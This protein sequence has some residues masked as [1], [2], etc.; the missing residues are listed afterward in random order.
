MSRGQRDRLTGVLADCGARV[1]LTSS[2]AAARV[3]EAYD[4]DHLVVADEV[5]GPG[6]DPVPVTAETPAYLQYTSGSTREPR[7]R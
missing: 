3:R 4:F 5:S 2:A 1:W 7:P 6:V